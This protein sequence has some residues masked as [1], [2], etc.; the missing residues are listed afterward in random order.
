MT[1]THNL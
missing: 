1:K